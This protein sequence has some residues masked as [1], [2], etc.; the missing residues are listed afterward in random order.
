VEGGGGANVKSAEIA[1]VQQDK[2]RGRQSDAEA[3]DD[4][5][6]SLPSILNPNPNPC[7]SPL[8]HD[9]RQRGRWL[10]FHVASDFSIPSCLNLSKLWQKVF[11]AQQQYTIK[12]VFCASYSFD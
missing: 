11:K 8:C 10:P 7:N 2:R 12:Q 3:K 5:P 1:Q 6:F 9:R 4:V